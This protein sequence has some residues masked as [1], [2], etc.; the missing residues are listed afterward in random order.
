MINKQVYIMYPSMLKTIFFT[1]Y[2]YQG[3]VY[4][5]KAT[6][7]VIEEKNFPT[8]RIKP[9]LTKTLGRWT[10]AE[11]TNWPDCDKGGKI[12]KIILILFLRPQ[13]E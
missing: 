9:D 10:F 2:N 5:D 12:L 7:K 1:S 11:T 8:I 3:D 6:N 4:Y 13:N